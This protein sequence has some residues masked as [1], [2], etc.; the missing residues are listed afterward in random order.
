MMPA[1]CA[2]FPLGIMPA[3]QDGSHSLRAIPC[4]KLAVVVAV[5]PYANSTRYKPDGYWSN[6]QSTGQGAIMPEVSAEQMKDEP[7]ILTL[8]DVARILRTATNKIYELTRG[9]ARARMDD[10]LPVLKIHSKML[11]VRKVD[12]MAWLDKMVEKQRSEYG[13]TAQ[14]RE[15]RQKRERNED[16]K[17]RQEE[18]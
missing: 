4:E 8:K 9:R 11:R 7:E 10:P 17:S 3:F 14:Q 2:R 1:V 12:L 5:L 18:K 15:N 6:R 13:E 16:W